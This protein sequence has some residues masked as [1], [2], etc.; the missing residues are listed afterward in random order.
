MGR[1]VVRFAALGI[2]LA[3]VAL[4]LSGLDTIIG[5]SACDE[6][7]SRAGKQVG[8]DCDPG[9]G[10]A[11]AKLVIGALVAAAAFLLEGMTRRVQQFG[12]VPGILWL[13]WGLG[14]AAVLFVSESS[15]GLEKA[16][17]ALV[18]AIT[19]A[20]A[21]LVSRHQRR[22]RALRT[23]G[24]PVVGR[25]LS[26]SRTVGSQGSSSRD[27]SGA[28]SYSLVVEVAPPG[29][30]QR[31]TKATLAV[32]RGDPVPQPGEP[33][34]VFFLDGRHLVARDAEAFARAGVAA[35]AGVG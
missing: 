1:G 7:I 31:Q 8:A 10:L 29:G 18:I 9:T 32:R 25:I 17:G 6:R 15:G 27:L 12:L 33:I 26:A 2:G 35:P 5:V 21:L 30:E 22:R 4:F 16:I 14:S 23:R 24:T 28:F 11:I 3:G 13:T 19:L 20:V 34:V